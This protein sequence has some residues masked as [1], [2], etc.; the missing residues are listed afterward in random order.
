MNVG[1][2]IAAYLYK[3]DHPKSFW[4]AEFSDPVI[5]GSDN[6]ARKTQESSIRKNKHETN[7][8]KYIESIVYKNADRIIF[9]NQN[10]QV[11]M[12]NHYN[13]SD[14]TKSV[15]K[16]SVIISHPILDPEY[17]HIIESLYPIDSEKINIAFFG[18]FYNNRTKNDITKLLK[19]K[20]ILLHLFVPNPD[21]IQRGVSGKNIKANSYVNHFEFLNIASRMDYLILNDIDFDGEINP[22]LPSKLADYLASGT[23]IL[24]L[25]NDNSPLSQIKHDGIIKIKKNNKVYM[26]KL[27]K[28]NKR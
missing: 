5:I 13:D 7:F 8:W 28:R 1:S 16:K 15:Q 26:F 25:I 19:N 27:N 4:I 6:H 17:S 12:L 18:S 11:F 3:T 23:K 20:N 21:E 2:H 14:I 22:Y 24:A 10:Q 9:T